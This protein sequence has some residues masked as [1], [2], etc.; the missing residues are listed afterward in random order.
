[1]KFYKPMDTPPT[2]EHGTISP[3][4]VVEFATIRVMTPSDDPDQ[5]LRLQGR[6]KNVCLY[7]LD[8]VKCDL[9]YFDPEGVFLGLDMTSFVSL[10]EIDPG[11]TAPFDVELKIPIEATRCVLNVHSKRVLQDIGAALK[12]YV[13]HAKSESEI[14]SAESQAEP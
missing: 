13:S 14:N 11:E 9:S 2:F 10:D 7:T 5:E 8:E 6:V 12:D 3:N 4:V 1:M